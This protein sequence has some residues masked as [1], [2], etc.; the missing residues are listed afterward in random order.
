MVASTEEIFR[1]YDIR[2]VYG[3]DIFPE[4]SL[5]VGLGFGA[6]LK[7]FDTV[8]VGRDV[9]KSSLPL[10]MGATAG[11]LA[12]GKNVIDIGVASTPQ[13]C[14]SALMAGVPGLAIG[15]SHNPA[16]YGGFKFEQTDGTGFAG[17]ELEKIYRA[18]KSAK[19]HGT[20]RTIG[21]Y[22]YRNV[23]NHYLENAIGKIEAT[24]R[25]RIVVDVSNGC[26][27]VAIDI[28]RKLGHDVIGINEK[29]DGL[30]PAHLPEP[31]P[32]TMVQLSRKVRAVKADFGVAFDGDADRAAFVDDTGRFLRTDSALLVMI[33]RALS[34][35]HGGTVL[36]TVNC[37]QKVEEVTKR[38][39][40]RTKWCRVGRVFVD[41]Y[42]KEKNVVIGGEES[43]HFWFPD[44]YCFSEGPAAAAKL[45]EALGNRRLSEVVDSFGPSTIVKETVECPE[46]K[47]AAAMEK[48]LGLLKK[49]GGEIKTIDGIKLVDDEKYWL[50]V[51]PSNTEPILK[52][53]VEAGTL[54]DARGLMKKYRRIAEDCVRKTG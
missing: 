6:Y 53:N 54:D 39:G 11:L 4:D 46:A 5:R 44:L 29:Q 21:K 8:I 40:G 38:L 48:L 36:A 28:L 52:L 41:A 43:G 25:L 47:K 15:A 14:F 32:E 24:R 20:G 10:S 27:G 17:G 34:K 19:Q 13:I 50:L 2:G 7:K 33:E 35:N 16:E 31:L 45:A 42:A 26:G 49:E 3:R 23:S 9:R 1:A 18:I 12:S 30:F 37:S 22:D 51:R